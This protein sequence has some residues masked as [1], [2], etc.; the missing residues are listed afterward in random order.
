MRV[1]VIGCVR[2]SLH[3]L[4]HLQTF[5][6]TEIVGIVT[7]KQSSFN[8]DFQSLEPF[9]QLNHIPVHLDL[10]NDQD[11]LY[12]FIKNCRPEICLCIGWPY[13]LS[14][15]VIEIP[16][17]GTI[18]YHPSALP[19]NRGRHPLIWTLTLGI[20]QTASTFFFLDGGADSGD[21]I[22]Q[23]PVYVDAYDDAATLYSKFELTAV[24][25][26]REIWFALI[27]GQ[28]SRIPQNHASANYWRKRSRRD[29]EI[30]W[31]MAASTI[32]DLV[33]ALGR[34]Y[35]GA[36]FVCDG[37]EIKVWRS[38]ILGGDESRYCNI[39]SGKILAKDSEFL[40]VKCGI[41]AI[42][43][44]ELEPCIEG[45]REGDYL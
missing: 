42:R 45:I 34:P 27:R 15:R 33:R 35:P 29:G 43:L 24:K 13:L 10:A 41:G 26:L 31:R 30:D 22:S 21:I 28:M 18:G 40:D 9:G 7:K 5:E 23:T 36:H 19:K 4:A 38:A 44:L 6:S 3:V 1:V 16:S 12:T 8:A 37:Q 17:G 32:H 2:F 39:E 11:A 25:Q 14:T 20:R